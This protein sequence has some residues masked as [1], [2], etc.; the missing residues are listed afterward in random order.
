MS[1]M[2]FQYRMGAGFQGDVNRVH[3]F[4]VEPVILDP[5]NPPTF[6]GEPVAINTASMGVRALAAGDAALTDIYGVLVRPYP[7]QNGSIDG[8]GTFPFGSSTPPALGRPMDVLRMGYIM[9]RVNGATRKGGPVFIWIA[10]SAGAHVQGGFEAAAGAAGETI[11][12]TL[13]KTTYNG[14]PDPNGIVELA[15]NI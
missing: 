9:V 6:F 13:P 4:S 5:T 10:A 7:S 1:F 8:F 12:L 15:Y 3:P 11:A 14:V 2:A